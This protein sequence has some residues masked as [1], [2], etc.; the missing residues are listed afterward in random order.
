MKKFVLSLM[1]VLIA[2]SV[3]AQK[4]PVE[5]ITKLITKN[6]TE[7]HLSFLAADEMRGRATGSPEIDIAANYIA[8]YF[9]QLGI[10]AAPETNQYFQKVEFQNVT[11]ASHLEF[12]IGQK[13]FKVK[14]DL[15]QYMGGDFE[16]SAEIVFIGYGSR[17]DFQQ[18]DVKGKIVVAFT[19][20]P[21]EN[22]VMKAFLAD[23]PEKNVLAKEFGALALVEIIVTPGVPFQAVA[24]YLV[25]ERMSLKIEAGVPHL[26]MKNSDEP[27]ITEL[28]ETKKS[29]GVLK[30]AGTKVKYL[31]GKNVAGV[32]QGTDPILKNEYLIISAH[33]DHVGVTSAPNKPDSIYNGARDN[34][35]G[36][37]GLM[38]TAKFF[39]T[40]PPKRSV[41]LLAV[42]AEE[43]GLLGSSWYADHP[44]IPLKQS[45]FNFNCDGA[46]YNDKTMATV[47]GLERTTAEAD[48]TK[49][50]AAFGLK[51]ALDP[52]PEQNLYERSDNYSFAVKGIP[53]INFSPGVKSFDA[54]LL[55][56]Y[57]QPADEVGS[58]DF[59]YLIKYFRAYVY[60][61]FLLANAPKAPTWK[62]GDK[63]EEAGKKLYSGN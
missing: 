12:V 11:P 31:N 57:H 20:K 3:F 61:N 63:F 14:D 10:Q 41:L 58:L 13:S 17:T 59:D 16:A 6:E 50:C 51:A 2:I 38:E 29:R 22:N 33:Y 26:W 8:T 35:I 7:A 54:E 15:V 42:T 1:V 32:I 5:E 56:Y 27:V 43:K 36:T 23:S 24:S 53:S 37:V 34:A 52:V 19:G 62:A 49:G 25:K 9:R 60:T 44:L 39:A 48:L 47:V 28:K 46:G 40:Y 55:K 30:I 21:E 4:K 45:V 18:T